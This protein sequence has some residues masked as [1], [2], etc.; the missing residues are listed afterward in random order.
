MIETGEVDIVGA[1]YKIEA[2][3]VVFL[4]NETLIEKELVLHHSKI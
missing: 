4:E 2:G 1:I 3:E